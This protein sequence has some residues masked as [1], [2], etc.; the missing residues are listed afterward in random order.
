MYSPDKIVSYFDNPTR[1]SACELERDLDFLNKQTVVK[2]LFDG[3]PVAA[4]MLD[5]NRQ[6]VNYNRIAESLLN[7][8]GNKNLYGQRIGEAIDCIHAFDMPAG[9]GTSRF[10]EECGAGKCNKT[11]RETFQA[12]SQECRITVKNNNVESA[13][14][15]RVHT[16]I[17]NLGQNN[18]TVFTVEDIQNEKRRKVLENIFFHDVLNT[19]NAVYGVA[20]IVK[21]TSE[22]EEINQFKDILYTSSEQL[23]KE[24]Q[25]QRDL[26]NAEQGTLNI[27]R[28]QQSVNE[29]IINSFNLYKDNK[30]SK[31]KFIDIALVDKDFMVN[32]DSVLLVRCIGNLIKNALEAIKPNEHVHVYA[33]K[34]DDNTSFYVKN[35]GII[36]V[37]IQL[38]IFQRSF[39][40]KADF[41]RGMGTYSV[42]LLVEQYLYGKV[43]FLSNADLGTIFKIQIPTE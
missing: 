6:I 19:A 20:Q 30:L 12:C 2:K 27:N 22:M 9:C 10:C 17:L 25:Y 32:T 36:P 7:P 1:S 23:I 13:L 5:K 26:V 39:S 41:G 34:E 14:D 33:E 37:N 11:T 35:D 3:F 31:N 43:S 38:Q 4:V 40:T 28:T 15:L 8:S 24:I 42:K 29:I 16:S 18:Y 21:D